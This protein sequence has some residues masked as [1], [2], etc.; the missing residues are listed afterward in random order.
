M[1]FLETKG[2]TDL[3]IG[4]ISKV[5]VFEFERFL[6]LT[7]KQNTYKKYI[8]T[9]RTAYNE[10][11]DSDEYEDLEMRDPFRA[12]ENKTT[13]TQE[14][15]LSIEQFNSLVKYSFDKRNPL[16]LT[17]A[18]F[19]FSVYAG[20]IRVSDLMTLRWNTF[21]NDG[22]SFYQF[23]TKHWH[24]VNISFL[25]TDI[26][27]DFMPEYEAKIKAL[28]EK[29]YYYDEIKNTII[30]FD[31]S[32]D[33]VIFY[34]QEL[35]IRYTDKDGVCDMDKVKSDLVKF[36]DSLVE[37]PKTKPEEITYRLNFED[38][39][40]SKSE[41]K[42]SSEKSRSQEVIKEEMLEDRLDLINQYAKEY[43]NNF[44]FPLL[45]NNDFKKIDF[46]REQLNLGKTLTDKMSYAST[47][48]NSDLK[49]LQKEV[50]ENEL[51]FPLTSH[52]ARHTTTTILLQRK[53]SLYT[54]QRILGHKSIKITE[55]YVSGFQ[56]LN[57]IR[58]ASI[59]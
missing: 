29:A 55:K 54:I 19:V 40:K 50:F 42:P 41:T 16:Y 30:H 4:E 58:E 37:E 45:K 27:F 21:S 23:K 49:K 18:Y 1:D 48:Y 34:T 12:F 13:D 47:L 6:S 2:K 8:S 38:T 33:F 7:I 9:F 26:L 3:L 46:N 17:K 52:I 24:Y 15:S 31:N 25:M 32:E 39:P 22:F 11:R 44:I 10:L 53:E 36:R 5:F 51:D 56:H 57:L 35:I 43:G 59:S 28:N 14:K 20:G